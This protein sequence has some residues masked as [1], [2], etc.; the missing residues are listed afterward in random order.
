MKIGNGC[1]LVND[2]LDNVTVVMKKTRII[3][4]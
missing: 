2:I 4:H 1:V 3:F